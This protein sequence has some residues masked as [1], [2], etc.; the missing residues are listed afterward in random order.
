MKGWTKFSP[1]DEIK[2]DS[3]LKQVQDGLV[4]GGNALLAQLAAVHPDA[5]AVHAAVENIK[6]Q[7]DFEDISD[8]WVTTHVLVGREKRLIT[9]TAVRQVS[10]SIFFIRQLCLM[11]MCSIYLLCSGDIA[12]NHRLRACAIFILQ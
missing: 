12:G 9:K 7:L 4:E 6:S 2:S 3:T 1:L 11:C 5:V 8:T 10:L